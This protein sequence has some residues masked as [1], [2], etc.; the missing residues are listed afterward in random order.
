MAASE[1]AQATA[2]ANA[3]AS[4]VVAA[5]GGMR[6]GMVSHA[7]AMA[8][9]TE[10]VMHSM[11]ERSQGAAINMANGVIGNANY[12]RD[13]VSGAVDN[14]GWRVESRMHAMR[15]RAESSAYAMAANV[16]NAV[17][18]MGNQVVF[19]SI[20]PK[21]VDEVILEFERMK[22]GSTEHLLAVNQNLSTEIFPM[23]N[24]PPPAPP[25]PNVNVSTKV[26]APIILDGR[27]VGKFVDKRTSASLAGMQRYM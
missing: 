16:A 18:G 14:M 3:M 17:Y 27:E 6:D 25:A 19:A 26:D 21:M 13:A 12:M 4:Q 7:S 10:S 9:H 11:N 24:S 1:R 15:E 20:V 8:A 5:G 23:Q 22:E 2:E